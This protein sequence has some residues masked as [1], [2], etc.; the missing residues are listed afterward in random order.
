MLRIPFRTAFESGFRLKPLAD[1]LEKSDG[2]PELSRSETWLVAS[3]IRNC[4]DIDL[5]IEEIEFEQQVTIIVSLGLCNNSNCLS[6]H[7][8]SPLSIR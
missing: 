2:D 5:E 8:H 7:I 1:K 4:A 3:S 6:V